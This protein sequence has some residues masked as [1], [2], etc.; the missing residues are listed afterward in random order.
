MPLCVKDESVPK[1][2]SGGAQRPRIVVGDLV[3]LRLSAATWV[4]IP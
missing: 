2:P 1:R 3:D 4:A